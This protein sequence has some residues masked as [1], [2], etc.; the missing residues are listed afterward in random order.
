[1]A[2]TADTS[3]QEC[4]AARGKLLFASKQASG[5]CTALELLVSILVVRSI[6]LHLAL[7]SVLF[8]ILVFILHPCSTARL[9]FLLPPLLLRVLHQ[10]PITTI[11]TAKKFKM[12]PESAESS[13]YLTGYSN[14]LLLPQA[15]F[16]LFTAFQLGVSN[17]YFSPVSCPIV[18]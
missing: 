15:H 17:A 4:A 3:H 10:S 8:S 11:F 6:F 12:Y 2:A 13:C 9:L 18:C 1:M 14:K 5:G 7:L 16:L